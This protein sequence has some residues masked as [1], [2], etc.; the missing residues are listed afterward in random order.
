VGF[1]VA[2]EVLV[3]VVVGV[4]VRGM[5]EVEVVVMVG[6]VGEV[7]VVGGGG[8]EVV[9]EVEVVGAVE[10]VVEVGTKVGVNIRTGGRKMNICA[11][12]VFVTEPWAGS[13]SRSRSW[14][15]AGSGTRSRSRSWLR[16]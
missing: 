11:K 4:K 10:V 14:A 15:R 2:V 16:C 1:E 6:V 13:V 9:G 5:G 7:E 12:A 8:D 3:M